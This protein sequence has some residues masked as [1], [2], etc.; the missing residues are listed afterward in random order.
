MGELWARFGSMAIGA[1]ESGW[2]RG[3]AVLY[4][5]RHTHIQNNNITT[6][7]SPLTVQFGIRLDQH[8]YHHKCSVPRL[9]PV[10]PTSYYLPAPAAG[11]A[12]TPRAYDARRCDVE[13]QVHVRRRC[14]RLASDPDLVLG[15]CSDPA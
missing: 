4:V 11:S 7:L 10:P 13:V 9:V 5:I 8:W 12:G 1:V 2:R 15:G 6:F 3:L 14:R